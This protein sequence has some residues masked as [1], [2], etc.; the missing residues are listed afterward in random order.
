MKLSNAIVKM[1]CFSL[2]ESLRHLR[3]N[4]G[5]LPVT[6][7]FKP[8]TIN[9]SRYLGFKSPANMCSYLW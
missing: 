5:E 2:C 8:T 7:K 9:C 4:I 3:E 1:S 6:G